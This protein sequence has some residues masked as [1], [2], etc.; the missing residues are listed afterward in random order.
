MR[1]EVVKVIK[2]FL[3]FL[4]ISNY[5]H[6]HNISPLMFVPHFKSLWLWKTLCGVEMQSTLLFNM[7]QRNHPSFHDNF[8]S[9]KS[10]CPSNVYGFK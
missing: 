8:L 10:Y 6:V 4:K 9:I 2:P 5:H 1:H 7:M 3:D